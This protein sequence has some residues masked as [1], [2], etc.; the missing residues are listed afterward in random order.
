MYYLLTNLN[1]SNYN[2]AQEL[3]DTLK[4]QKIHLYENNLELYQVFKSLNI[5]QTNK[6]ETQSLIDRIKPRG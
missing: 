5:L 4:S 3:N 1:H 6:I 2:F